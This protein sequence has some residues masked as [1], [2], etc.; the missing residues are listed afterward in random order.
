MFWGESWTNLV[1]VNSGGDYNI[2]IPRTTYVDSYSWGKLLKTS[3]RYDLGI[4]T[5][6][7]EVC[8]HM[9]LIIQNNQYQINNRPGYNYFINKSCTPQ[10][11]IVQSH[12]AHLY[13]LFWAGVDP[14]H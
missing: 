5:E 3:F 13:K 9:I 12:L 11:C 10:Y 4:S 2:W 7:N 8:M 6:H 1:Q 14:T